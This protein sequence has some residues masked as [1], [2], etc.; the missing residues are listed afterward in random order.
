MIFD[1]DGSFY[2]DRL[3]RDDSACNIILYGRAE[4]CS[5]KLDGKNIIN[6]AGWSE[7]Q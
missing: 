6:V 3:L 5:K 7:K 2:K 4:Y 1:T